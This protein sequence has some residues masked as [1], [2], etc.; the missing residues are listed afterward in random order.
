VIT[1]VLNIILSILA[2]TVFNGGIAGIALASCLSS[3]LGYCWSASHFFTKGCTIRPD[4]SVIKAPEEMKRYMKEELD[5]GAV[6]AL[7]AALDTGVASLMNK[8]FILAG[9]TAG[10]A[11]IGISTNIFSIASAI[12]IA[13]DNSATS[14]GNLFFA[15][16]DYKG[17]KYV[18][19]KGMTVVAVYSA[20]FALLVNLFPG[21]VAWA[22]KVTDPKVYEALLICLRILLFRSVCD[23]FTNLFSTFMIVFGQTKTAGRLTVAANAVFALSTVPAFLGSSFPELMISVVAG[24]FLISVLEGILVFRA[25]AAFDDRTAGE[26]KTCSYVLSEAAMAEISR[27]VCELLP[28][29]IA[30]KASLLTEECNKLIL[31]VNRDR[32]KPILVDYRVNVDEKGCVITLVDTGCI[33][34][35][36]HS[37]TEGKLPDEYVIS[38]QIL[39]GFSPKASYSRVVDLN[40]SHLVIGS[41]Q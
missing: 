39:K 20:V 16:R 32:K 6:Y 1:N 4:F 37:L 35:P 18:I 2:V 21:G 9:G 38:R 36:L 26:V 7:D 15:D 34:D 31:F 8:A 13:V 27:Q 5:I 29:Q 12:P 23:W 25:G 10:L 19:R 17:T 24:A 40:I 11:A 3:L 28:K 22:Y 14:L 33:F 41:E 30:G